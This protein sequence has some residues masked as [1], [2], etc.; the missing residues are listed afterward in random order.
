VT[1]DIYSVGATFYE[2][3]SGKPPFYSGDIVYQVRNK[4][5]TSLEQRMADLAVENPAPPETVVMGCLFKNPEYRPQSAADVLVWLGQPSLATMSS[6]EPAAGPSQP[7]SAPTRRARNVNRVAMITTV[8]VAVA[9]FASLM[10]KSPE[11]ESS[12][13]GSASTLEPTVASVKNL[14]TPGS[15]DLS[16]DP[17]SGADKGVYRMV[18]RAD[19]KPVIIGP[20][21]E[22]GGIPRNSIARLNLDGSVDETFDIGSGPAA[23]TPFFSRI[24]A[25]RN[26][27][28]LVSGSFI[29]VSGLNRSGHAQLNGDGSVDADFVI[30][31]RVNFGAHAQLELRDGRILIGGWWSEAPGPYDG[32]V[33][34]HPDGKVDET[35]KPGPGLRKKKDDVRGLAELDDG[36]IIVAG[37]FESFSGAQRKNLLRLNPDGSLDDTFSAEGQPDQAVSVMAIDD[38]GRIL[39]GGIFGKVG[40]VERFNLARLYPDGSVDRSFVAGFKP[41]EEGHNGITSIALQPDGK[42]LVAGRFKRYAGMSR[43]GVA[44]LNQDGSLDGSFDSGPGTDDTAGQVVLSPDGK[45]YIFGRFTRYNGI[46][47][48]GMARLHGDMPIS[49]NSAKGLDVHLPG[50]ASAGN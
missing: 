25:L 41:D 40:A 21:E 32:L 26:G 8:V 43:R 4:E 39:I 22:F 36:K 45:I 17:G 34:I 37:V 19:G 6:V 20:F 49:A 29:S 5:A 47:R 33:M 27:K 11:G 50:V 14:P 13:Q 42:I 23:R 3:I 31:L 30:D 15:L 38:R 18:C 48:N 46:A 16:F 2:L 1:D 44:R 7:E 9:A 28:Y 24:M 12:A 35:F 10:M